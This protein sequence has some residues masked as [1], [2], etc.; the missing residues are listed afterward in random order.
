MKKTYFFL[1]LIVSGA[2]K[3]IIH[4]IS[5]KKIYPESGSR[6][7]GVKNYRIPDPQHGTD[8]P[9]LRVRIFLETHRTKFASYRDALYKGRIIQGHKVQG[10]NVEKSKK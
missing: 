9:S 5:G 2:N 4:P 8:H 7:Q 3:Q 1:L 6:I 10:S